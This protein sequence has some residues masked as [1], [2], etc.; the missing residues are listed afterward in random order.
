MGPA[1]GLRQEV[2]ASTATPAPFAVNQV[3]KLQEQ[4]RPRPPPSAGCVQL[5]SDVDT[6]A[7]QAARCLSLLRPGG[8]LGA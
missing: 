2:L 5:E 3:A 8:A 1:N 4:V 6:C 7:T